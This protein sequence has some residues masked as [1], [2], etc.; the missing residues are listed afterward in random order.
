M[1]GEKD[2]IEIT[3]DMFAAAID[4]MR[5]RVDNYDLAGTVA[6]ILEAMGAVR[7]PQGFRLRRRTDGADLRA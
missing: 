1:C 6:A 2:D 7:G 5:W 4:A 3:P